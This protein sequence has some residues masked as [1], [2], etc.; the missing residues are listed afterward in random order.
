MPLF[1]SVSIDGNGIF[2]NKNGCQFHF[3]TP[4]S[5]IPI[6]KI[7][8]I[9]SFYLKLVLLILSV[10]TYFKMTLDSITT[11]YSNSENTLE[12]S[13]LSYDAEGSITG[14]SL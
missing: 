5:T 13:R 2:D 7:V 11:R 6:P 10:G 3:P 8:Q 9:G 1:T 14:L 4:I 12:A